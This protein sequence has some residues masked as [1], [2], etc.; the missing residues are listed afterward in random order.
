MSDDG[1]DSWQA[2]GSVVEKLVSAATPAGFDGGP[3]LS[4]G[5]DGASSFGRLAAVMVAPDRHS[6]V[7]VYDLPAAS[8]AQAKGCQGQ[9]I[10]GGALELRGGDRV[11]SAA[12]RL[13]T[14]GHGVDTRAPRIEGKGAGAEA[15][16]AS[17]PGRQKPRL[18]FINPAAAASR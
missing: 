1:R 3:P 15:R 9:E 12:S 17:W 13:A 10:G 5:L 14:N 16:R 8:G 18:V 2:L 4:P 7:R 11:R 6:S